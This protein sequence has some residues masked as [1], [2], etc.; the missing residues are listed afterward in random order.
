MTLLFCCA[1]Q[2]F[3]LAKCTGNC[4]KKDDIFHFP[5]LTKTGVL[6]YNSNVILAFPV[7][8]GISGEPHGTG[9]RRT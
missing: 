2:Q 3:I 6:C 1:K 4:G 5:Q 9:D 7:T 8:D